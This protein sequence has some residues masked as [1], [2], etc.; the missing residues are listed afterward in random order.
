MTSIVVENIGIDSDF[1]TGPGG[2]LQWEE[3]D[4]LDYKVVM[5]D[6]AGTGSSHL[7]QVVDKFKEGPPKR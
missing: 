2:Y 4:L 7:Q 3:F 5:K 6:D 1:D